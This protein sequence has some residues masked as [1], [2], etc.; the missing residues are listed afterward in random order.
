MRKKILSGI[1]FFLA[2]IFLLLCTCKEL[3]TDP[4]KEDGNLT[5]TMFLSGDALAADAGDSISVGLVV[6]IPSLVKKLTVIQG[7]DKKE[8][9]VSLNR[10]ASSEADTVYFRTM[11][12]QT[13]K[14]EITVNGVFADG[15]I[16]PFPFSLLVVDA[17]VSLWKQDT[18]TIAVQEDMIISYS[19]LTLLKDPAATNVT[20]SSP[21]TGVNGTNWKYTIAKGSVSKDTISLFASDGTSKKSELK[22]FLVVSLKDTEGPVIRLLS[23]AQDRS[24]VAQS[25]ATLVVVCKDENGISAVNYAFG[26]LSGTMTKE[27]DSTYSFAFVNLVKGENQISVVAMDA[28]FKKNTN[29]TAF[30]IIYDP[31]M[32]DT[33]APVITL[34]TPV[35]DSATVS[36]KA[37]TFEVVCTD[38]SGIDTVTCKAGTADVA[39]VRGTGGVFSVSVTTLTMGSNTFTFTATDKAST[40]RSSTKSVTV[41]YDPTITDN[42]APTVVIKNPKNADQRV[43]TDTITV[44]LDCTDDSKISSV[45]ATRG[46]VAVTGITNVGS[47]YSV[48]VATLTP[49]KSDTINFKVVDSSSNKISKDFPVILRYNRT[50]I[51]AT[52]NLPADGATGIIK[53]GVFTWIDGTDPDSDAVTYTL[54]Y[55]TS[56]TAL[57]K[58][59]PNITAK[60]VVLSA[61]LNG[62]TKY[63]WQVVTYTAANGDSAVSGMSSFTTVEDAPVITAAPTTQS[64][65]VGNKATFTVTATGLNLKY[66]WYKGS[67]EITGATLPAYTTPAVTSDVDG[68]TYYCTVTNGG[69]SVNTSTASLIILYG[70]TYNVNEATSGTAPVDSN[71]YAK[72]ESVIVK[73]GTGLT[74]TNFTFGGWARH[75]VTNSKVYKEE[76]SLMISSENVTLDAVWNAVTYTLTYDG[77]GFTSG[78]VPSSV[79]GIVSGASVTVSGAGSL[80]KTNCEFLGWNTDASAT[81]AKYADASAIIIEANTKLYAIWNALPTFKVTYD[82]NGGGLAGGHGTGIVPK[83]SK[84]YT[85]GAIVTVLGN[86]ENFTR[87]GYVFDGWSKTDTGKAISSFQMGS[88]NAILYARWVIRDASGNEYKEVKIGNQIWMVENLKTTKLNDGK[89]LPALT[90][91]VASYVNST[92]GVLYNGYA[93][94]A[95]TNKMLA[96][97]GWRVSTRGDWDTLLITVERNAKSLASKEYWDES[98]VEGAVG[99]QASTTNNNNG[100]NAYPDGYAAVDGTMATINYGG[101]EAHFWISGFDRIDT[102]DLGNRFYIDYNSSDVRFMGKSDANYFASVRCIREY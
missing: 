53:K 91:K 57:T 64:V 30:T 68:S 73:A 81:T 48:K 89:T 92:Y 59:V 29:D 86:P 31:T 6:N 19:L 34:K 46:G 96:P 36:S 90:N 74:R 12:K 42:V 16:K 4:Y 27:N 14:K 70:V 69:G 84:E 23:P 45:T 58:T 63:Y 24:M 62:A 95:D 67:A 41:V 25:S 26:A 38:S 87:V 2:G 51:A 39:V 5:I 66:Q 101:S 8:I 52:L 17:P 85:N 37:M 102:W 18:M 7:D 10:P 78:S 56:E 55:G 47:L 1:S 20:F 3:P 15:L 54:R 32:N 100:F 49:G 43:F 72:G 61:E 35:K 60:T 71:T 79:T 99:Y 50:P 22:M 11:Y 13:G 83:D 28:S 65:V 94:M 97:S 21:D 9:T 98:S 44:Q 80:V 82:A 76:D 93:V 88:A 33:S 40:K 77:N 75:G